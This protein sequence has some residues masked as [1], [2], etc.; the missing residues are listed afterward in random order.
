LSSSPLASMLSSSESAQLEPLLPHIVEREAE[1]LATLRPRRSNLSV[2]VSMR[3]DDN[4]L[5]DANVVLHADS[6]VR[7]SSNFTS[8]G[9]SVVDVPP[10][11]TPD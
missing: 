1:A 11:Y 7:M 5:S 8:T 2:L 9:T 6:G 4:R 3:S 10:L